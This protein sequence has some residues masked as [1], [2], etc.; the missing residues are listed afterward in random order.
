[1]LLLTGTSDLVR[2]VTDAA[3]ATDVHASYVDLNGSTVTPGR[4]NT[5]ITTAATTTVV[6]SPSASTQ[7]TVKTLTVRNKH[8]SLSQG[9]TILHTDGTT[10]VELIAVSLAAGECLHF[11]EAAGFWTTDALGRNK[12]AQ[13]ANVGTPTGSGLTTVVLGADVIN[14]NGVANTIADVTGL[15]FAVT[16]NNTFYFQFNILFTAAATTT[17]SRWSINGPASPTY[18]N[19]E[20]RYSLTTT[21]ETRNALLQAYDQP[22]A[23]NGTSATTGNNWARIEG[24]IRPTANGTVI[25]RF[26]SE[27]ASSAIVAKVGSFVLYQQIA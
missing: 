14:N 27:V 2:V 4:T 15:S 17:G 11:H 21:T 26:A 13:Y 1:M 19:Y 23:A 18:L 5:A 16:A 7:R 20:S 10:P 9:V 8:A 22:S 6:G 12:T 24:V 25:A 3:I